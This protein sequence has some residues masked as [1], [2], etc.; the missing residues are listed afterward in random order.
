MVEG[1][2]PGR[3]GSI[4][5][6]D[7]P[8]ATLT[9]SDLRERD[10]DADGAT[11]VDLRDLEQVVGGVD[12]KVARLADPH[13]RSGDVDH[14]EGN[15]EERQPV[16]GQGALVRGCLTGRATR[17]QHRTGAQGEPLLRGRGIPVL[18]PT[19]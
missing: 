10:V 5:R 6:D 15:A 13:D 7:R 17:P 1:C 16:N 2:R 14:V 3:Q 4:G 9:E 19:T 12:A 18:R 8:D 11:P